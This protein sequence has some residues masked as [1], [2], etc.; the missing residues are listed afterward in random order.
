MLIYY[1][2]PCDIQVVNK[3]K[4]CMCL[5]CGLFFLC[6]LAVCDIA[7]M[8]PFCFM[9]RDGLWIF[10]EQQNKGV[11]FYIYLRDSHAYATNHNEKKN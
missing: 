9:P 4:D 5:S 1:G 2:Q 6:R 11:D 7:A 8:S 10:D 3:K